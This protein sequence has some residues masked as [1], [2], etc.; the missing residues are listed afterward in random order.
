VKCLLKSKNKALFLNLNEEIKMKQNIFQRLRRPESNRSVLTFA[1]TALIF[2]MIIVTFVFSSPNGG[3]Q[4][5]GSATAATV[6]GRVIPILQLQ[7]RAQQIEEQN[8]MFL[9]AGSDQ[10]QKFFQA[11]ALNELINAEVLTE[12]QAQEGL[13]VPD[14]L[15]AQTIMDIPAFQE[16][17]RFQRD[18]YEN[19]LANSGMSAN[20]LEERIKKDLRLGMLRELF[21]QSFLATNIE[22]KIYGEISDF[23][24]K[25]DYIDVSESALTSQVQVSKADVEAAILDPEFIKRAKNLFD[26]DS[27]KYQTNEKVKA[28][29][30]LVLSD[31]DSEDSFAKAKAKLEEGTKDLTVANFAEKAKAIS[32]DPTADQG[33]ELGYVEKGTFDKAWDDVAF[34]AK[35]GQ[36]SKPFKIQ[37]GWAQL[38]VEEKKPASKST[39]EDVKMQISKELLVS[40]KSDKIIAKIKESLVKSP[41]ELDQV[42]ASMNLKWKTATDFKLSSESIPGFGQS[43][44]IFDKLL[45][46]KSD[47][48]VYNDIVSNEGK[49]YIIKRRLFDLKK[50]STADYQSIVGSRQNYALGSWFEDQKENIKIKINGSLNQGNN[51]N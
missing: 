7:Q 50:D 12:V 28:K 43:D 41:K 19:Y 46:L 48:D 31:S 33:G 6:G 2:G 16:K 3:G 40:E 36:I 11:Q 47:G 44:L 22:K 10:F 29:W 15:L 30:I 37:Q 39:F 4:L 34:N 49:S 20:S 51:L 24:I 21:T 35:V 17:G 32:Q 45:T 38:L 5:S 26:R 42:L 27:F 18:L 8:K 9:P 1:I 13:Y 25:M 14:S 23:N